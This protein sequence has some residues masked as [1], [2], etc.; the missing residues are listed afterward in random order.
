MRQF[1]VAVPGSGEHVS[2]RARTLHETGNWLAPSPSTPLEEQPLAV[3]A[4][5][6]NCVPVPALM[7]LVVKCYGT[8]LA[9]TCFAGWTAGIPAR[10]PAPAVSSRGPPFGR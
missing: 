6:A 8:R 9:V 4:E 2:L 1:G 3:L 5:E 10:S 7:P